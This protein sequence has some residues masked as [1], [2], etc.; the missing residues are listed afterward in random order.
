M[1][2]YSDYIVVKYE[3]NDEDSD[4]KIIHIT[5]SY[6]DAL[7]TMT[8]YLH[9]EYDTDDFIIRDRSRDDILVYKRI[10]GYFFDSKEPV[11]VF[12]VLG[13]NEGVSKIVDKP[14]QNTCE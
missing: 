5:T 3:L 9:D 8:D 1:E 10:Q 13:Y 14:E 6:S 11:C 2:N 12:R 7:L 4:M